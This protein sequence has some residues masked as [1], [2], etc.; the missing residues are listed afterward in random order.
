MKEQTRKRGK[1]ENND[2]ICRGYILNGMSDSCLISTK[3]L[4]VRR[5]YG[6]LLNQNTLLKMLLVR[7][8]L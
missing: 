2:Y 4:K 5:H 6:I 3:I 1:L 8:S 7:S